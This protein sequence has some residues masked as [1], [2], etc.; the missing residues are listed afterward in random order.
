MG[1][2][3]ARV[4]RFHHAD[5]D[6]RSRTRRH[7][8]RLAWP[9]RRRERRRSDLDRRDR[10]RYAG[11]GGSRPHGFVS[12]ARYRAHGVGVAGYR[13]GQLPRYAGQAHRRGDSLSAYRRSSAIKLCRSR[14]YNAVP[15]NAGAVQA[16]LR[17]N[18][19]R[20]NTFNPAGE[21]VAND[22]LPSS[23]TAITL[24]SAYKNVALGNVRSC[25]STLPVFASSAVSGAGPKAPLD[26]Y[27][28]SPMRS[29]FPMCTRMRLL[30]Q[31]SFT[32]V[33]PFTTCSSSATHPPLYA[34][35]TNSVLSPVHSGRAMLRCQLVVC[36]CFHN[37]SPESG[38]I[39]TTSSPITATSWSCPSTLIRIGEDGEF[40]KSCFCQTTL[41]SFWLKAISA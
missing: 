20:D 40:A 24:P 33:L 35:E 37:R 25:H 16:L 10:T 29:R 22:R 9:R 39:P 15:T 31:S 30:L 26:P 8:G 11:Q 7:V 17:S 3:L 21:T 32:C 34:E 18:S 19:A 36:G 6:L 2:R 27:S 14:T 28:V 38:L 13:R 23:S 12:P 1:A 4:P 5:C 41:P